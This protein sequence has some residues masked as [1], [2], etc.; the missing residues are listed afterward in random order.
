[1]YIH[2]GETLQPYKREI[3]NFPNLILDSKLLSVTILSIN[4]FFYISDK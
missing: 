2:Y 1:M 3:K 4:Q